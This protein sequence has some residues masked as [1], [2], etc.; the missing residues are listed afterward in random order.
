MI[1]RATRRTNLLSFFRVLAGQTAQQ[2]QNRDLMKKKPD[3]SRASLTPNLKLWKNRPFTRVVLGA[4]AY[5]TVRDYLKLNELEVTGVISY[6]KDRLRG[7]SDF[8]R[9]NLWNISLLFQR[10]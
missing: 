3:T 9:K 5:K 7:L 10:H 4:R 6:R 1:I 8:E 2:F